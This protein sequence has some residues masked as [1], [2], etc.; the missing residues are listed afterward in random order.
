[1]LSKDLIQF[2]WLLT[3]ALQGAW[4]ARIWFAGHASRYPAFFAYLSFRTV[5]GTLLFFAGSLKL[6]VGAFSV[7]LYG[8]FAVRTITWI[9]FFFVVHELYQALA[10]RYVGLRRVG[11]LVLYGA[12]GSVVAFLTLVTLVEPYSAHELS[13]LY[14]LWL[15]HEQ[16]VYLAVAL[17]VMSI[18]LVARF[19]SLPM[20]RNLRTILGT[21]GIYI[22]GMGA[23]IVLRSFL[24]SN[25][26]HVL[27]AGGLGLYCVCL[28]IGT[29]AYSAAGES[30]EADPRLTHSKEHLET[31]GV[32]T[33]RLEEVNLQLVRVLAK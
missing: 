24:G 20:S 16:S 5:S 19:F 6:A 1:M 10:I 14:R 32:A 23:M 27:D 30:V 25:W 13:Q 22:I 8:H 18:I 17:G 31:L 3:L 21:L 2:G 7:S 26:N 11:R 28:A 4:A 9:L 15:I 33:R 12:L 29:F